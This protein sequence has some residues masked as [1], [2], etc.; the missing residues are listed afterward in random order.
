MASGCTGIGA[1]PNEILITILSSFSTSNLLPIVLTSHRI[2]DLVL[3]ILHHRLT[4]AASLK[5][6]KLI[7]DCFHPSIKLSTPYLFCDYIGTDGLSDDVEGEGIVYDGIEK[8][9]RLGK[10]AGLYSHFRPLH[11]EEDRTPLRPHPVGGWA[12][13]PSNSPIER[14]AEFVCQNIHLESHELFSQLVV[15]TNLVKVGPKRGLYKSLVRIG[16]GIIRIFR[17]WLSERASA[18]E[19]K[20]CSIQTE[21]K[22]R[23]NRLQWA[24]TSKH[25]G[26]RIKVAERLDIN[27]PA[28]VRRDEDP[29]VS[30]TLQY[31]ELVIR[32]T[33]LLLMVEQSL[34]QE[35]RN[36]GKAIVIGAWDR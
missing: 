22:E 16:E 14:E 18:F 13:G 12:P 9:G 17:P 15:I 31:E 6:H 30:Y 20:G 34:D 7:L 36:S 11:P 27:A 24:D 28:L 4:E 29:P 32:T 1:L 35:V 2:H 3:R 26:V 5:D 10:L 23:E 21:D 19:L 25:V 8:T 33:Q